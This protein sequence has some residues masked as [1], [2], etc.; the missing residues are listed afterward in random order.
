MNAYTGLQTCEANRISWLRTV[1]N[2]LLIS[3]LGVIGVSFGLLVFYLKSVDKKINSIWNQL[4]VITKTHYGPIKQKLISRLEQYHQEVDLQNNTD[5]DHSRDPIKINM[6]TFRRYLLTITILIGIGVLLYL[7]AVYVFY[8]N[9]NFFLCYRLD[10]LTFLMNRRTS[11]FQITFYTVEII[12]ESNGQGFIQR[13]YNFT[14]FPDYKELF[15][16]NNRQLG[17][18]QNHLLAP[19][20]KKNMPADVFA[21]EFFENSYTNFLHFG[22][23]YGYNFLRYEYLYLISNTTLG[24]IE[25]NNYFN[26]TKDGV[27]AYAYL[28]D[29]SDNESKAQIEKELYVLIYFVIGCLGFL[30]LL[31]FTYFIPYFSS[32]RKTLENVDLVIKIFDYS[33][34]TMMKKTDTEIFSKNKTL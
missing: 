28:I 21:L 27:V 13:F 12:A 24:F 16:Y 9:I 25:L 6:K 30:F 8:E 10:F 2:Y 17:L 33:C 26:E 11:L 23:S 15:D 7:L 18:L 22:G 29:I 14:V 1:V 3:G 4:V 34:T 5:Q 20:I 19:E 32:E 31:S